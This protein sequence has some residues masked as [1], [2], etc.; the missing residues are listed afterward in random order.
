MIL[1]VVGLGLGCGWRIGRLGFWRAVLR[2]GNLCGPGRQNQFH[3]QRQIGAFDPVFARQRGTGAGDGQGLQ[4]CAQRRDAK[5]R[6][7]FGQFRDSPIGQGDV[8]QKFR[9]FGQI[10]GV[11]RKF[12]RVRQTLVGQIQ[13]DG[14]PIGQGSWQ[15]FL[16]LG[17]FIKRDQR[18]AAFRVECA[19]QS[20]GKARF[21]PFGHGHHQNRRP[22][23][24]PARAHHLSLGQ[25][26][27]QI[28]AAKQGVVTDARMQAAQ[29]Q[30]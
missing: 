30:T 11:K 21:H 13:M 27:R 20:G 2:C 29:R 7:N 12:G 5:T 19:G 9:R 1:C 6:G 26:C 18:Q 10:C 28:D 4:R 23:Q 16:R 22:T 24:K 14:Q 25:A 17:A 8:W 3:R 15:G